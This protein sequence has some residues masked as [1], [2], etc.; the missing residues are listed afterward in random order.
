MIFQ[1][2]A[3]GLCMLCA[4]LIMEEVEKRVCLPRMYILRVVIVALY[5]YASLNMLAF[6]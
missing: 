4:V 5:L 3:I 2:I 6:G 1:L